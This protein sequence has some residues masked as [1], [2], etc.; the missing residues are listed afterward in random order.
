MVTSWRLSSKTLYYAGHHGHFFE[1]DVI[2]NLSEQGTYEDLKSTHDY[3]Y[4]LG[5]VLDIDRHL[6]VIF[7]YPYPFGSFFDNNEVIWYLVFFR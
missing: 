2:D 5:S 4:P 6:E 3:P 1:E 7:I